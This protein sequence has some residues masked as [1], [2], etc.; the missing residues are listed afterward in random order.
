VSK[1][2]LFTVQKSIKGGMNISGQH[3]TYY[4]AIEEGRSI[5]LQTQR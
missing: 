3:R 5:G 1:D 2:I 4:K